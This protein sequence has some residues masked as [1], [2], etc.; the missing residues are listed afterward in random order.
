MTDLHDRPLTLLGA[1]ALAGVPDPGGWY[2]ALDEDGLG[3][4]EHPV[5]PDDPGALATTAAALP[6]RVTEQ[7]RDLARDPRRVELRVV[8][9][10]A[11]TRGDDGAGVEPLLPVADGQR[12]V[13]GRDAQ[14]RE[15]A[16]RARARAAHDEVRDRE[17]ELH[18][19]EVLAHVVALAG[20]ARDGTGRRLAHRAVLALA[21]QVE[22]LRARPEER[23]G[24]T[25]DRL[26]EALRP[27]RAAGDDERA[28]AG[29]EAEARRPRGHEVLDL[30]AQRQPG[31]DAALERRALERH[32]DARGP[33]GTEAVRQAGARV[34]L[35]DHDRDVATARG[36]VRGRGDVAPEADDD[37]RAGLVDDGARRVHGGLETAR[38]VDPLRARA[39]RERD[40]RHVPQRVAPGGDQVV[41]Q[42]ARDPER[43]HHHAG[44][45][46]PELV[47]HREE[48]VHVPRRP[49][50]C[51]HHRTDRRHVPRRP[52]LRQVPRPVRR[53]EVCRAGRGAPTR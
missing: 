34:L 45:T 49:A 15:L 53:A 11:A 23:V 16:H 28:R 46:R 20:V 26:V 39:A 32:A 5:D 35:V 51:E 7:R 29:V 9:E 4:L 44:L 18:L 2:A 40:A 41:L 47:R 37:A 36:E 8:D 17:R 13:D 25:G 12:H 42:A 19:G 22:D 50:A 21:R 43:G 14:R 38:E 31:D 33:P 27:Q 24:G 30:A 1:Y 48:R 6:A 3:G 10:Q 52:S